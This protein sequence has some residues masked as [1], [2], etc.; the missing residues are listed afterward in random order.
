MRQIVELRN[1]P[2]LRQIVDRAAPRFEG[3]VVTL[4]EANHPVN[5]TS[6]WSE[7][8]KDY[9]TFINLSTLQVKEVPETNP[10]QG[11]PPA[12]MAVPPGFAL[13]EHSYMG[14]RQSVTIHIN[15]ENMS[16]LIQA[17]TAELSWAEKV[18]LVA[19]R[20]LKSTYA[21]DNQAR[22]HGAQRE[23]GIT[24]NEWN[25][26]KATLISKKLLNAAG[27]ITTA[28][29]NAL[30]PYGSYLSLHQLSNKT[31]NKIADA[32]LKRLVD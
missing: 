14:T 31:A 7:G 15:P 9:F 32:Y 8:Y 1:D 19:T 23:T 2:F 6:M 10:M 21:G 28:G 5:V 25:E 13:V 17:P 29:R 27:A 11:K 12:P 16:K 4:E 22:F 24:A 3:R 26:A 18:V 20:S 30:E